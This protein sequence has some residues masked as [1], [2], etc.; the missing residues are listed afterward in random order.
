MRKRVNN[1]PEFNFQAGTLGITDEYFARYERISKI[2]D[3]EPGIVDLVHRDLKKILK[4]KLGTQGGRQCEYTSDTILRV[5]LC[6][7]IQDDSLRDIVVR[8]DDS[9]YLRRFTRIYH[10]EMMNYT[11]LC[12]FK[13]AIKPKTWKRVNKILAGSAAEAGIISGERLRIDTSAYETN[14]R[15]PSDSG[16]LWDTY[17]V[18]SKLL[19]YARKLDPEVAAGRRFQ[20]KRV[21][22]LHTAIARCS[23]RKGIV[24]KKLKGL[25]AP[26]LAYVDGILEL[27][28][29]SCEELRVGLRDGAYGYLEGSFRNLVDRLDHFRSLGLKVVDQARRRVLHGEKVPNDEKIFSIFEPHTELLKRG[30]AG[31]PIEFGHMVV[32]QQ[33]DGKFISDYDVFKK[34]PNDNTLV[35]PALKSHKELFG[36]YP[37]EFSADKG[38]YESMEKIIELEREIE[39]VSIGKKGAR[40]EKEN[41][42]EHS[43]EFRA[44]QRFRAGVEGSISFLKRALGL[45]RCLNKGWEHYAA[46][47]G[48]TVFAHNLLVLARGYG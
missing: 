10:G 20:P 2:L 43:P 8:I 6:Q 3:S 14:I 36:V 22:K 13:N 12:T 45:W 16:L 48:A 11:T 40:T 30:K 47:F 4:R 28:D 29:S 7:I 17:R 35:E 38:F 5:L 34:K 27:T 32:L 9:N 46:T 19:N 33:V 23:R 37:D 24:S 31:K 25:Y 26:L 21:K 15:W 39:M 18:L 1:Q 42:R 44:A 41:L